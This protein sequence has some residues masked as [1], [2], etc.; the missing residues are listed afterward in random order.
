MKGVLGLF[1]NNALVDKIELAVRIRFKSISFR[2][3][4]KLLKFCKAQTIK[5]CDVNP[6]LMKHIV[7]NLGHIIYHK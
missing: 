6:G 4:K 1:R 3:Q 5:Y 2:Y 7:H